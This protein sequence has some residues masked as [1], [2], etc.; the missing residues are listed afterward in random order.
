M[1]NL[2]KRANRY[3]W[4]DY[5]PTKDHIKRPNERPNWKVSLNE[6]KRKLLACSHMHVKYKIM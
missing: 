6:F 3:E 5:G 1:P 4:T 2:T